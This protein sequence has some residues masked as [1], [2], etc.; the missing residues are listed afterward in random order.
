[1]DYV[2]D[3]KQANPS[4]QPHFH[5]FHNKYQRTKTTSFTSII[6]ISSANELGNLETTATKTFHPCFIII[7]RRWEKQ[8]G[9]GIGE[10]GNEKG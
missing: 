9:F 3:K 10:G 7:M 5:S 4:Y 8:K 2:K 1:M 6:I